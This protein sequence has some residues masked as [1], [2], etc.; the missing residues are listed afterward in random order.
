MIGSGLFGL[1]FLSRLRALRAV[2]ANYSA[3]VTVASRLALLGE[4]RLRIGSRGERDA[5]ADILRATIHLV[6][7]RLAPDIIALAG[8]VT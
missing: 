2:L 6:H 4:R 5:F 7:F 8:D 1:G 3:M